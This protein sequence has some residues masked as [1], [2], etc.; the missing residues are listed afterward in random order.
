MPTWPFLVAFLAVTQAVLLDRFGPPSRRPMSWM[1]RIEAVALGTFLLALA[2]LAPSPIKDLVEAIFPGTPGKLG[3]PAAE[4]A[5]RVGLAALATVTLLL[6]GTWM[7]VGVAVFVTLVVAAAG[8]DYRDRHAL[9]ACGDEPAQVQPATEGK[10]ACPVATPTPAPPA[11]G[12]VRLTLD[13]DRLA[14]PATALEAGSLADVVAIVVQRDPDGRI[15][16]V[17]HRYRARLV[18]DV[19]AKKA[20]GDVAVD[21]SPADAA[22]YDRLL[23][24]LTAAK[25][26]RLLPPVSG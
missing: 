16:T 9:L 5:V 21:Y 14:A 11:S 15:A 7:D 18:A 20:A 1:L 22:G 4:A 6:P 17:A 8:G 19:P 3:L 24:D 10:R 12:E 26:L 25:T 13:K 2:V 23:A